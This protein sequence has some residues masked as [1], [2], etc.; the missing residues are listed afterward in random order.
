MLLFS[1]VFVYSWKPNNIT[2]I[3]YYTITEAAALLSVNRQTLAKKVREKH[4]FAIRL[5][6]SESMIRIP[7]TELSRLIK[8][9]G[10]DA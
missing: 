2:M 9:G 7:E 5:F 4:V 8:E 10:Q 1:V 6:G 3:K